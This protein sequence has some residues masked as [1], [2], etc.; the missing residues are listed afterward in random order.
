MG[1]SGY[2]SRSRQRIAGNRFGFTL[3]ELLIVMAVS[4]VVITGVISVFVHIEQSSAQQ[5]AAGVLQQ[6]QRGALAIMERELRLIGMDRTL[7]GNFRITDVRRYSIAGPGATAVPDGNGSPVLRM[8]ID[9]NEDGVLDPNETVT[10][11]LYD[12][13]GDGQPPWELGRS[14]RDMPGNNDNQI[15]DPPMIAEGVE[16]SGLAFAYAFDRDDDGKLDRDASG[17]GEI[18]WAVDSDNDGTLD[19]EIN[20]N[21]IGQNVLPEKIKGVQFWLLGRTQRKDSKHINNR[22]YAVGDQLVGPFNDRHRRW[23]LSEII[24]CRNL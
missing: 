22:Q 16:A 10:Y 14:T 5:I 1:M 24:H 11:S 13:N 4:A 20:G 18:I 12:K 9:L 23:L 19:T 21:A 17:T 6:N 15:T 8:Q 7:S 2:I 3:L